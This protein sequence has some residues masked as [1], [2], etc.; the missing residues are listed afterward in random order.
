MLKDNEDKEWIYTYKLNADTL[1]LLSTFQDI[2]LTL[3]KQ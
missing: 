3:L 2:K 1:V